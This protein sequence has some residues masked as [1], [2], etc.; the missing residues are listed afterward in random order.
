M[1]PQSP[2]NT[3]DPIALHS[4]MTET[5]FDV[6]TDMATQSN[7]EL[8]AAAPATQQ[9]RAQSFAFYGK[10]K[11]NYLFLTEEKQHQWMSVAALD[12][13][14]KTLAAL[15]LTADDVA[16]LNVDKLTETPSVDS[17][18]VFFKPKVVVCLGASFTWPEQDGITVFR[19]HSFDE[20]LA[21][22]EKKR[23]FWSTIKTLLV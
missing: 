11:R 12:A 16:V 14:T 1:L 3:S 7:D 17:I 22:A 19:T 15:K 23:I 13:F 5:I 18:S 10:N 20:L 9:D 6:G 8:D 21:D 4:L 2:L